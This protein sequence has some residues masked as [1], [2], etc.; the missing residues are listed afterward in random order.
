M[1]AAMLDREVR[2]KVC[3]STDDGLTGIARSR[4]VEKQEIVR[5]VLD[6]YVEKTVHEARVVLKYARGEGEQ[7]RGGA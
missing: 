7:G 5:E 1:T 3:A 6:A 4:G 2:A